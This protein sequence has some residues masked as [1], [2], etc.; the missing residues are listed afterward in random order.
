MIQV[1]LSD[2]AQYPWVTQDGMYLR[3]YFFVGDQRFVGREALEYVLVNRRQLRSIISKFNGMFAIVAVDG[4]DAWLAVDRNRQFPLFVQ[5][6]GAGKIITDRVESL[7][8]VKRAESMDAA[9]VREYA[10]TGFITGARTLYPFV[11]NVQ[12]GEWVDVTSDGAGGTDYYLHQHVS[13][14]SSATQLLEQLDTTV[15][16]VF[17]RMVESLE[18]REVALLLSGGY[19]SRLVAVG[20]H[21]LGYKNVTCFSFG[22]LRSREVS[23]ARE[24]A[25]QLGY[26]WRHISVPSR[27]IMGEFESEAFHDFVRDAGNGT[28]TPYYMGLL[29]SIAMESG[30]ISSEAVIVTG[31]SGDL[32]EGDQIDP[33]LTA[34]ETFTRAEVVDSLIGRHYQLWGRSWG[35][36]QEFRELAG[37]QLPPSQVIFSRDEALDYTERFNWRERQAKYVVQDARCYDINLGMDWR[38][39]LWDYEFMDFWLSVPS[40]WRIGRKLYMR[41]VGG[42]VFSTAN[43]MTTKGR[44]ASWVKR[45]SQALTNVLYPIEKVRHFLFA[46]DPYYVVGF[47]DYCKILRMTGGH[48]TAT[49]TTHIY[50]ELREIYNERVPRQALND[51]MGVRVSGR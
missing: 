11:R 30:D 4:N 2:H 21:R 13:S 1:Q 18:G 49:F 17:G 51:V 48:R 23:V 10:A 7:P 39:P 22:D 3:G 47:A 44:L 19:D 16:R 24:V 29:M 31:S 6:S 32:L 43:V 41:Y 37:A 27:F 34:K 15:Q 12:A 25:A 33:K 20:L 35:A 38:F 40:Q 36:R 45:K 5:T 8:D 46:R 14:D 28:S 50:R 26:S 42:E 9:A